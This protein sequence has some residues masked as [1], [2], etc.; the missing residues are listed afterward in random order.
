MIDTHL[1]YEAAREHFNITAIA[2][3]SEGAKDFSNA[4]RANIITR[5]VEP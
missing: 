5:P 4:I 3:A 1:S 2:Q